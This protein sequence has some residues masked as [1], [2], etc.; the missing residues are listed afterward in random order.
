MGYDSSNVFKYS[1]YKE[2]GMSVRCVKD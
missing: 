1:D 2:M